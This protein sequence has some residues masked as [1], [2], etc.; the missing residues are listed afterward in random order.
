MKSS[1]KLFADDTSLF[2]T[3][4]NSAESA[5]LLNDDRKK[6]SEWAFIWKMLFNPDITKQAQEVI[7]SRKSTITNHPTVFFNEAPVAHTSCQ[8]HL[9]LHLDE[10]LNFNTHVKEKITKANKGI[11]VIRKVAHVLPRE[12]LITICKSFVRPPI[13]YG[14]IIVNLIIVLFVI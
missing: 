1:A 7:F 3:V 2:S 11:G 6:I 13:D 5:N 10:K 9:G 14:D 4:Y 8:K 12:S